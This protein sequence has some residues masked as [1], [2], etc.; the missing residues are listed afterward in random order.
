ME[1]MKET[2]TFSL[3]LKLFKILWLKTKTLNIS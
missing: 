2:K 3:F 1:S